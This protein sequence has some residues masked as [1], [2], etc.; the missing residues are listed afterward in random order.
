[1]QLDDLNGDVQFSQGDKKKKQAKIFLKRVSRRLRRSLK[2]RDKATQFIIKA[3]LWRLR[4]PYHHRFNES[5]HLPSSFLCLG[6]T[7]ESK[8]Q[9]AKS[10][11]EH[12]VMDDGKK[13]LFQVDLSRCTEPDSFFRFLQ[14]L[15][16]NFLFS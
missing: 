6:L 7:P 16:L 8:R 13:L 10:L 2:Q 3:L 15:K 4:A 5:T 9:F 14:S 11:T 1:M 12:L